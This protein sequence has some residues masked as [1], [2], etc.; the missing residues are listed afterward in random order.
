MLGWVVLATTAPPASDAVFSLEGAPSL[1]LQHRVPVGYWA[2]S[3]ELSPDGRTAVVASIKG[4]NATVVDTGSG[5]VLHTLAPGGFAP[6]EVAFQPSARRALISG[7]FL[8]HEVKVYDLDTWEQVG[9]LRGGRDGP[10]ETEHT[11]FPKV[12][13]VSPDESRIYVS[14]W[15]SQN[16]GVFRGDNYRRVGLVPTGRKPRGIAITPDGTKG[17]VCNFGHRRRS[18][19]VFRADRRPFRTLRTI[20]DLPNP[21][22]IV[23]GRDGAS[24]YVSLFGGDGGVAQLDTTRDVV[25]AR[26][27][28]TGGTS[29]TLKLSPD[30]QWIFLVNYDPGTISI[31]ETA[32]LREVARYRAGTYPQGLSVSADGT[33][34]W[35]T[36]EEYLRIWRIEMPV[37]AAA[38]E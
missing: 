10:E 38:V 30:E 37:L 17:Y 3:V 9:R 26:S 19:T 11:V 32:S 15:R 7:G 29:K 35:T 24:A 31:L 12:V 4:R 8:R 1:S 34:L 5:T 2:K 33:T 22:H 16:V 25:V 27:P 18:I 14:Y 21:R 28:G 20:R 6:V 13:A 36:E 23:M